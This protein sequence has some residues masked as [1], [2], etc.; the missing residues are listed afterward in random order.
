MSAQSP[1]TSCCD[2]AHSGRENLHQF[3][4]ILLWRHALSISIMT[5]CLRGSN[6]VSLLFFFY[7]LSLSFNFHLTFLIET[8]I[9]W[10]QRTYSQTLIGRKFGRLLSRSPIPTNFFFFW[11]TLFSK[12]LYLKNFNIKNKD[13]KIS[14][15]RGTTYQ[16][17]SSWPPSPCVCSSWTRGTPSQQPCPGTW[18]SSASLKAFLYWP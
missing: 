9:Y 16:L 1:V 12:K 10:R 18:R 8:P 15:G 6:T 3:L 4:P 14:Q 7:F 17:G 11:V 5:L 13:N 2:V